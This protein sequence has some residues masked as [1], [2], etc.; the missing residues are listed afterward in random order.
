MWEFFIVLD[1]SLDLGNIKVSHAKYEQS[2]RVKTVGSGRFLS[3]IQESPGWCSS[4]VFHLCGGKSSMIFSGG[5]GSGGGW[6]GA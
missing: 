1:S 2:L 3:E 4:S 5:G 6:G